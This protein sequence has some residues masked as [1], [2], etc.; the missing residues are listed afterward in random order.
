MEPESLHD[1]NSRASEA[2]NTIN[3][4][5]ENAITGEYELGGQY[6]DST[7]GFN[8]EFSGYIN[9]REKS[10]SAS[11]HPLVFDAHGRIGVLLAQSEF[12][13][14]SF[15]AQTVRDRGMV[16]MGNGLYGHG[17]PSFLYPQIFDIAG[18]ETDWQGNF[19]ISI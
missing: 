2:L 15:V 14:L 18:T 16:M 5:Y 17:S 7:I 13:F 11:T 19:K 8:A 9:F 4:E 12:S 3:T 1:P 6:I 10:I